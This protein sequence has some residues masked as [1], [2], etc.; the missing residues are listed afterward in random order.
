[1]SRGLLVLCVCVG[2]AAAAA[3]DRKEEQVKY[4]RLQAALSELGQARQELEASKLDY[5][6]KKVEA[7]KAINGAT[8]SLKVILA[9]EGDV[10]GGEGDK[11]RYQKYKDH[12]H[13]RAALEDLVAARRE[14]DDAETD[15]QGNR[16]E[17]RKK[18]DAA[19][20]QLRGL[21]KTVK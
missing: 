15:F 1:M 5:G 18:I 16:K 20:D 2:A 9:F 11:Q 14:L 13:V 12:P 3:D 21:L 19:I 8:T 4:P 6:G 17:A 7:I 10:K